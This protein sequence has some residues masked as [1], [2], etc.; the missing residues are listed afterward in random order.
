MKSTIAVATSGPN[1]MKT[2]QVWIPLGP[3]SSNSSSKLTRYLLLALLE[4]FAA[5][6]ISVLLQVLV[7][8]A[9]PYL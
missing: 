6:D 3:F 5:V 2:R 4:A 1:A 7:R 8:I 9:I